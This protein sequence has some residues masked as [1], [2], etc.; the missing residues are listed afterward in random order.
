MKTPVNT[1]KQAL[2]NQQAQIGL[3]LGLAEPYCAE[4]LAGTGY[5]WRLIDGG[6]DSAAG[7]VQDAG[8]YRAK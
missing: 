5:D 8:G 7:E 3:W 6:R 1:F 4:I 2:Q